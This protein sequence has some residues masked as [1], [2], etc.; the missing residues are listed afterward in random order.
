MPK[1]EKGSAA[2]KEQMAHLRSLR[3]KKEVGTGGIIFRASAVA[4]AE[5]TITQVTPEIN[6][7]P[8]NNATP[9]L[10]NLLPNAVVAQPER[11]QIIGRRERNSLERRRTELNES[12]SHLRRDI[13]EARERHMMHYG[14]NVQSETVRHLRR[15]LNE[16]AAEL[17]Y[18]NERLPIEIEALPEQA[19]ATIDRNNHETNGTGTIKMLKLEKGSAAAKER[20]A[21]LRSL[22]KAKTIKGT[23]DNGDKKPEK[24]G[25]ATRAIPISPRAS[26]NSNTPFINE[27]P[28]IAS[29]ENVHLH[30]QEMHENARLHL[31]YETRLQAIKNRMLYIERELDMSAVLTTKQRNKYMENW[32]DLEME[33]QQLEK[34]LQDK[35]IEGIV[36][37]QPVV[38]KHQETDGTGTKRSPWILHVSK[39]AKT[40]GISYFQALKMPEVREEYKNTK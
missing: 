26:L 15:T 23:G 19:T 16:Y 39:Y 32:T 31:E 27:N 4:P 24:M 38:A 14:P 1:L 13:E 30:P 6:A 17:Q 37:K 7:T 34:L 5:T 22:R 9:N 20:M 8:I 35:S 3:K 33:K 11:R 36:I 40:H 25:I 12:I 18:I 2:A 29:A 10:T 28:N 21:H